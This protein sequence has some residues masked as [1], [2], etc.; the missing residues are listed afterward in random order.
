MFDTHCDYKNARKINYNRW[1]EHT[2]VDKLVNDLVAG[3]ESNKKE[4][5]ILNM[6]VLVMD[7]YHSHLT[8]PEQY[9]SYY[10]D[11]NHYD[12]KKRYQAGDKYVLNPHISYDYLIGAVNHLIT[13]GYISNKPGQNFYAENKGVYG[14]LPKM[15]STPK[16]VELWSKYGFTPDMIGQW[17]KDDDIEVILLKAKTIKKK[18]PCIRYKKVGGIVIQKPGTRTIKIKKPL[19]YRDSADSKRMRA[20]IHA[21]NR[22]MDNTHIDCDAA[23]ISDDDRAALIKKLAGY[24]DK[25]PVIRLRLNSKHVY[26]VFN[27]G[28]RTFSHGGRYYGAWWIGCQSELRKYITLNGNPTV[29]LDY[30]GIHIHLLY[31]LEG[32][33]YAATGQDPYTLDDG[34]PDRDFNKLI[35]L[36]ALNADDTKNKN[37]ARDSVF[38]AMR[39]EKNLYKYNLTNKEPITRKIQLLKEKHSPIA[40][41]I[42]SGKGLKL[43]YY[44]SCIIEKLIEYAVRTNKPVLTIHDS[45]ICEEKNADL[46]RDKMFSYFTDV[47]REKMNLNIRHISINPHAK[48]IFRLNTENR[49]KYKIPASTWL[50]LIPGQL[51][52]SIA[53]VQNWLR[54]DELIVI[55]PDKRSNECSHHCN[56]YKRLILSSKQKRML[57][58]TITVELVDNELQ[59]KD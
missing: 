47:V 45:V 16:L 53:A 9:L 38:D 3:I 37:N 4:G 1:S 40:E 22:L 39:K 51:R 20:I 57:Y 29:E 46:I 49:N 24:E 59:I 12:F 43:Q 6:K 23:C 10:R 18:I 14:F 32:I 42:A 54:P 33:N 13:E 52:P 48:T 35:L 15:R 50:K 27:D 5:Y 44:D 7:L 2:H 31:A 36:T 41:Y 55:K 28:D 17:K 25:E 56:H 58:R 26:R 34:I 8:D 19:K 21:Y 30:S 11:K